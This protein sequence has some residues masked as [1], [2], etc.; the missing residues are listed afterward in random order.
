MSQ[1]HQAWEWSQK[2]GLPVPPRG[3]LRVPNWLQEIAKI[4]DPARYLFAFRTLL[5]PDAMFGV[6]VLDPA[7]GTDQGHGYSFDLI[8]TDTDTNTD[9]L[10][11]M[12]EL[13]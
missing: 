7:H 11:V 6:P 8:V 4:N 2:T 10:P 1:P 13:H 9:G 5:I 3:Y 12:P